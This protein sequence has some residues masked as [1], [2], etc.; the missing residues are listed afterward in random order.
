MLNTDGSIRKAF[1]KCCLSEGEELEDY[2]LGS[3]NLWKKVVLAVTNRNRF[4]FV[5]FRIFGKP[6]LLA[7]FQPRDVHKV[8]LGVKTG[9]VN[10]YHVR[11]QYLDKDDEIKF[12]MQSPMGIM[13]RIFSQNSNA[14]PDYAKGS[15]FLGVV[16][17]KDDT[18]LL[19]TR[20]R[21][22]PVKYE[23]DKFSADGEIRYSD[24][25]DYDV[26]KEK[27]G[28]FLNLYMEIQGKPT[29]YLADD[30]Q[31]KALPSLGIYSNLNFYIDIFKQT[32]I[33]R[34]VPSYMEDGEEE[35]VTFNRKKGMS[36]SKKHKVRVATRNIY[37]LTAGSNNKLELEDK[38]RIADIERLQADSL[39]SAIKSGGNFHEIILVTKDGQKHSIQTWD[40]ART[41]ANKALDYIYSQIG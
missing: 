30:N 8:E 34:K 17:V 14:M 40:S 39:S 7:E 33:P 5:P 36:L 21:I 25:S 9:M 10:K 12:S 28:N 20:D 27:I 2:A 37:L 41:E 22:I 16:A 29:L 24:I 6:R 18:L 23:K 38:V 35:V 31:T 32:D 13:S 26:Y 19:F 11:M 1:K 15:E 4:L 3:S